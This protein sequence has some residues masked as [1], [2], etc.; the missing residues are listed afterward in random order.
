M[1]LFI[2][3]L[4]LTPFYQG[5]V[6]RAIQQEANRVVALKVSRVSLRV[7]RMLLL[8]EAAM[9]KLL[10]RHPCIPEVFAYGRAK[11]FELLS[12]ELLHRSLGDLVH[13]TGPLPFNA[14]LH[15]TNQLV[16]F[17]VAMCI[18]M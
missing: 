9:L 17:T 5:I 7:Q 18:C 16:R 15:I 12:L 8:Y 6:Y 3:H 13:E 4:Q 10:S 1:K 2:R 14:V 11:H